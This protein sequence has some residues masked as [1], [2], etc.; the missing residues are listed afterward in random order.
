MFFLTVHG[1]KGAQMALEVVIGAT[2]GDEEPSWFDK[3]LDEFNITADLDLQPEEDVETAV[4]DH[5]KGY[6]FC[7]LIWCRESGVQNYQ[8][9]RI[10]MC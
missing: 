1:I 10:R 8:S 7:P 9:K 4:A 5:E 2:G 6:L 3:D